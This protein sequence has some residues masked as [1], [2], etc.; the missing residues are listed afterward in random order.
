MS[1]LFSCLLTFHSL[2]WFELLR[3]VNKSSNFKS[4]NFVFSRLRNC[5]IVI[6]KIVLINSVFFCVFCCSANFC[7]SA[8]KR[9]INSFTSAQCRHSVQVMFQHSPY[10]WN[11]HATGPIIDKV[12]LRNHKA[13]STS[14]LSL[15]T[16]IH[17]LL[18]THWSHSHSLR[19]MSTIWGWDLKRPHWHYRTGEAYR[20]EAV[21]DVSWKAGTLYWD[22]TVDL[23][24]LIIDYWF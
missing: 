17:S 6:I 19:A 16:K 2:S 22:H 9:F 12:K 1:H 23:C 20:I 11:L 8:I 13:F 14:N 10:P 21:R 18:H 5:F 7:L 24:G 15:I 3:H 4:C